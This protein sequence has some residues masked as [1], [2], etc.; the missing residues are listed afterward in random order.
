MVNMQEHKTITEKVSEHPKA[1]M[2]LERTHRWV[3]CYQTATE[4]WRAFPS[5]AGRLGE[6]GGGWGGRRLGD[7]LSLE[8]ED[9][10]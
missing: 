2:N 8:S 5:E 10:T 3:G 4:F 7:W 9:S 1:V 6:A